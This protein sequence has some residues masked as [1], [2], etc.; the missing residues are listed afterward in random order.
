MIVGRSKSGKKR[1]RPRAFASFGLFWSFLVAALAGIVLFF[2]PEGSLAAW[3]GWSALSLDKSGWEGIHTLSVVFL[4]FFCALHVILNWNALWG[5]L[6]RTASSFGGAKVEFAAATIIVAVLLV[7]AIGRW[8]PL[9]S[10][11]DA[12]AAI[13][14]GALAV[15]VLPPSADAA[16]RSLAELCPGISVS[17]DVALDRLARAGIRVDDP[18]R[19]LEDLAA[20]FG[21]SPERLYRLMAGR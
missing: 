15:E 4:I 13:K 21:T 5:Y 9:W 12:R 1:F 2:R 3:A 11:M 7:A 18:S 14:K 19:N 10:L 16:K 20:A 8:K 17:V 6:R